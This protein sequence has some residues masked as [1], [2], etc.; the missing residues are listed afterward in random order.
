MQHP[1]WQREA[2]EEMVRAVVLGDEEAINNRQ[3]RL[4][5][6]MDLVNAAKDEGRQAAL[7][8]FAVVPV[9]DVRAS[10]G[11]G[12]AID[13]ERVVS[14]IAFRRDWLAGEG[15]H[16]SGL[17]AVTADGDSMEP[18]IADGSLLL[19]DTQQREAAG[20]HIYVL[21]LDGHIY[22][23]RLQ[24]LS[25]GSVRVSSDNKAYTDEVVD[26]EDAARLDILGRVVWIGRRA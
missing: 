4:R 24:R 9:Y 2:E 19:V 17:A 10:A 25:D 13:S 7:E 3:D 16:I 6:T 22:A 23:K 12:A 26:R 21:R 1:A 18:T 15:L 8:D 20:A 11:H 14:Q 5:A